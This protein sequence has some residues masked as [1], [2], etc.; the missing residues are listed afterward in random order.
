MEV[1]VE[2]DADPRQVPASNFDFRQIFRV[3]P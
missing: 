3:P 1:V 2:R